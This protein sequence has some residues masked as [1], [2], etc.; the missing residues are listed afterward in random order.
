LGKTPPDFRL[1]VDEEM[2]E[3]A[4]FPLLRVVASV[5]DAPI[6]GN[7]LELRAIAPPAEDV[8]FMNQVQGVDEN[9]GARNRNARGS[10]SLTEAV[11]PEWLHQLACDASHS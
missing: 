5:A 6:L 9:E 4:R 1:A 3:W 11:T 7:R 8:P 2:M 10:E